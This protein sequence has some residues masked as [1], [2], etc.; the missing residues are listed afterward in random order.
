MI[1][2]KQNV[3]IMFIKSGRGE[4]S[5]V[6]VVMSPTNGDVGKEMQKH[7]KPSFP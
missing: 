5:S 2:A 1:S 4:V 3:L 6:K 7:R